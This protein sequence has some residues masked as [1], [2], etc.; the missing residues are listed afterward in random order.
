MSPAS[1]AT[2]PPAT[3]DAALPT[4]ATVFLRTFVPWQIIRF[5]VI[6]V[7]MLR[8]IMRSHG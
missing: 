2:T 3:Q 6:N 1:T 7:K 4:R 5:A 8:L